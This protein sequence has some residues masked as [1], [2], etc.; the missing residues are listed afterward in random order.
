MTKKI[1]LVVGATLVVAIAAVALAGATVKPHA[2]AHAAQ[3]AP[4]ASPVA[5]TQARATMRTRFGALRRARTA[6]DALTTAV[7]SSPIL[8]DGVADVADSRAVRATGSGAWIAP[9]TAA[10]GTCLVRPDSLNCVP[11]DYLAEHGA[12]PAYT[13]NAT[14]YT[15]S[16]MAT[17]AVASVTVKFDGAPQQEVAVS[18]NAFVLLGAS[19]RPTDVSWNGPNGPE[20]FPLP[21]PPAVPENQ[22]PPTAQSLTTP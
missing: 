11:D 5:I 10:T 21:E 8:A 19:A 22:G 17:D 13:K 18:N 16:G 6:E 20:H 4:A 12:A 14:G 9:Q 15:V 2:R 7:A 1:M 3:L